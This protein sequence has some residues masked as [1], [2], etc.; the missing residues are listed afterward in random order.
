MWAQYLL[1]SYMIIMLVLFSNFYV[2][3]YVK[4]SNA[5]KKKQQPQ[6]RDRRI[7][8]ENNNAVKKSE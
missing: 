1:I 4:K 8:D 5:T 6:K 3:E 2:H 7:T